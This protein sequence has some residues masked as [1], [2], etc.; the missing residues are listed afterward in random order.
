MDLNHLK[1]RSDLR[2]TLLPDGET[3]YQFRFR[4]RVLVQEAYFLIDILAAFKMSVA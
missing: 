3:L 2:S 1:V 4:D